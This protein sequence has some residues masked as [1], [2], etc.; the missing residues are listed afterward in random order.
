MNKMEISIKIYKVLKR[1]REILD[2]VWKQNKHSD[3]Q[4]VIYT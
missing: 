1:E 4:E 3:K 2:N